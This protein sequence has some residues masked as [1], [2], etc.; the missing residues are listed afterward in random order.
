MT[1]GQRQTVNLPTHYVLRYRLTIT[2]MVIVIVS[3]DI[4]DK[5]KVRATPI[6]QQQVKNIITVTQ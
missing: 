2:N 4:S 6:L 3:E 5:F 1:F